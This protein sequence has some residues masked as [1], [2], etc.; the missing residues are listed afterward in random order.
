MNNLRIGLLLLAAL[1]GG[2]S[3]LSAQIKGLFEKEAPVFSAS[4]V[5]TSENGTVLV[6][7]YFTHSKATSIETSVW[8]RDEGTNLGSNGTAT[9]LRGLKEIGNRQQDTLV[10][11]GLTPQHFYTFGLDYRSVG[12]MTS[13]F[14][15][16]VLK[17]DF[18]YESPVRKDVMVKDEPQKESIAAPCQ[19]P[20][21]FVQIEPNG[22]CGAEDRPAVQV[23]CMNCKGVNW[24]FSVQMRSE[25][26]A[27]ESLRTDGL[28]QAAAGNGVR[29]E[30]LCTVLPGTYYVRVLARGE[31]CPN[32][33]VHNV[34]TPVVIRSNQSTSN[35]STSTFS[36][37]GATLSLP[38]T[39]V[40][41]TIAYKEGNN[42][43]GTMELSAS[44]PCGTYHPYATVQYVHP[45][46]RDI[47][48]K[49]VWLTAGAKTPFE[50]PLDSRDMTRRIQTLQIVTY[51]SPEAN[52]EGIPM[53]AYWIKASDTKPSEQGSLILSGTP[54][55][56]TTIKPAEKNGTDAYEQT[57]NLTADANELGNEMEEVTVRASDPNCNQI[58]DLRMVYFTNQADRPLY[59]SWMNPR[60]CQE[61][62]C[63]YTVWAGEDP[64]HLRILVE[65]SKRGT[66]IKEL[67]QDLTTTDTYV[68]IGVK[69][70]NGTRKA[71]YV[72][73]EGAKYGIEEILSY[74]DR[75]KPQKADPIVVETEVPLQNQPTASKDNKP[76]LQ[77][78]VKS[79]PTTGMVGGDLA[80]RGGTLTPPNSVGVMYQKS[81][82][83]LTDFKPCKYPRETLV[84]GNRPAKEGEQVKI[85]YDFTDKEYRY[86]LYLQPQ[87]STEWFVA[88]GTK[89]L[90][91]SPIFDLKVTQFY[92]GKYVILVKKAE[93][94]WGCL[95]QP[96]EQPIEIQVVKK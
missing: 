87:N 10:V 26:G 40:V 47:T 78:P 63:K 68:E 94:A 82:L 72:I 69:T 38:D 65:G 17:S 18:R 4:V 89:E 62:G 43:K 36:A 44:S 84:V 34:G 74:R 80:A 11:K 57:P 81:Q 60:C 33:I 7:F 25:N 77:D 51:I 24:D 52:A 22:Y 5:P 28:S 85:Q 90:Q 23:Q 42:I 93:A 50:I 19:N 58:Q 31:N 92:T 21:I 15:S 71:A 35:Q 30:P 39:C 1:C 27:W 83:L 67:V 29:V 70:S 96:I 46:Y 32:S 49:P 66:F 9:L 41:R 91:E 95:A 59:V 55:N 16:T 73:G 48:T 76:I 79:N 64:D 12:F 54:T 6:I 61:D 20:D 8:L 53:G 2:W 56:E 88:P 37:K 14:T 45:G 13:K 75:L 86:T 3:P